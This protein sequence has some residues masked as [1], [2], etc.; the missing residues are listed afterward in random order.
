MC[1]W[2]HTLKDYTHTHNTHPESHAEQHTYNDY[3]PPFTHEATHTTC[4]RTEHNTHG[5]TTSAFFEIYMFSIT[6]TFMT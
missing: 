1:I 4:T 5:V 2:Q 6:H 3:V